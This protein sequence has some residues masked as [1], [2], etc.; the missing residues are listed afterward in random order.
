MCKSM[1]LKRKPFAFPFCSESVCSLAFLFLLCR[2]GRFAKG[3]SDVSIASSS[4]LS[5]RVCFDIDIVAESSERI[6]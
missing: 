6:F 3:S 5:S 1:T 2:A 4:L